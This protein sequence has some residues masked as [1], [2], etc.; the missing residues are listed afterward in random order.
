[1]AMRKR[2]G[3]ILV[4]LVLLLSAVGPAT[5]A[6]VPYNYV[7]LGDSI[8]AGDGLSNVAYSYPMLLA[9]KIGATGLSFRAQSGM[10][11]VEILELIGTPSV[12]DEIEGANLITVSAGCKDLLAVFIAAV[13]DAAGTTDINELLANPAKLEAVKAALESAAVQASFTQAINLVGVTVGQINAAIKQINP[14]AVVVYTLG[15]N[16]YRGFA[17]PGINLGAISADVIDS[18]NAK[19]RSVLSGAILVD[20]DALFA[21][22]GAPR[23]VNAT[24]TPPINVDPHPNTAGHSLIAQDILKKIATNFPTV[25]Y[26]ARVAVTTTSLVQ[27]KSA[28]TSSSKFETLPAGSSVVIY[29]WDADWAKI[30]R[31][32]GYAYVKKAGL[33]PYVLLEKPKY[34]TQVVPNRINIYADAASASDVL[35]K[36]ARGNQLVVFSI[37]GKWAKVQYKGSIGYVQ[38]K[39]LKKV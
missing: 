13:L 29:K 30:G 38:T 21:M 1:M 7:S 17:L 28:S 25:R 6:T 19:L 18:L 31:G 12:Q 11:S 36:A 27:Y 23:C 10:T 39:A 4:A 33:T 35:G 3:A 32:T 15:Y 37:S 5:A 34:R 16:P 9:G 14:S 24:T 22:P 2:F 8:A 20:V 26:P